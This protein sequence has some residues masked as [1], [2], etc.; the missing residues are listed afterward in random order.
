M[1][2]QNFNVRITREVSYTIYNVVANTP[3]EAESIAEQE[4]PVGLDFQYGDVCYFDT[5]PSEEDE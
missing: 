2:K 5:V 1:A 4:Q 3:E